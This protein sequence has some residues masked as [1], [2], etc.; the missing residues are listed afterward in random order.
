M[1]LPINKENYKFGL[2]TLHCWIRFME[3]FLHMPY[4]IKFKKVYASRECKMLK[5]KRKKQIALKIQMALKSELSINVDFVKQGFGTTNDGNTARSFF[6]EPEVVGRILDVNVKLIQQFANI[7]HVI[8]SGFEI[9]TNKFEQYS[10]E[11]A[12][13]FIQYYGWYK[14]PPTVHKVLLHGSKIMQQFNV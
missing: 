3:C 10:L 12:K 2:S 6:S 5:E 4:N 1:I 8:S 14:M 9:D 11:T 7:L 13:L